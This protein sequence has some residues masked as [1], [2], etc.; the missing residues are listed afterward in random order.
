MI[1]KKPR[2]PVDATTAP[3]VRELGDERSFLDVLR[4]TCARDGG[5]YTLRVESGGVDQTVLVDRGGPF[6]ATGG[7]L[8]GSP[9]L[10]NACKL[11]SGRCSITIGWPVDQPLY[12]PGLDITL[13][14]L[15]AGTAETR[16]L[17]RP[18]GVESLR[19]SEW[20]AANV[21]QPAPE[22][23]SP[24]D[25]IA[26]AIVSKRPH[27]APEA[28]VA[29]APVPAAAPRPEPEMTWKPVGSAS[30]WLPVNNLPVTDLPATVPAADHPL[31]GKIPAGRQGTGRLIATRAL[32]WLVECEDPSQYS[33]EQAATMARQGLLAGIS[34][35]VHPFRKDLD[36]RISRVKK[37]WEK[38]GEVAAEATRK[39]RAK[40][41]PANDDPEREFR[42]R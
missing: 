40:S 34:Q 2:K 25:T 17:P 19:N 24:I 3:G 16:A 23:A 39:K 37:D 9:A 26:A 30:A 21:G 4:E 5:R 29:P 32:L 15:V 31:A 33:L 14:T 20:H 10:V 41:A 6:N 1:M 22:T 12:Q 36:Q 13:K 28:H 8:A 7:G 42:L 11:R 38:S 27:P 18:R 35:M